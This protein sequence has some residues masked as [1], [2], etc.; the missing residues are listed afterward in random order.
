[1]DLQSGTMDGEEH[2]PQIDIPDHQLLRLIGR[3]SYGQV[4]IARNTIGTYRAV[5]IIRRSSFQHERPFEREIEG[6]RRFEPISRT[7]PG[8]VAI[9]HVGQTPDGDCFYYVM[10]LGDDVQVREKFD[11]DKYEVKTLA[12]AVWDQG[13][14][15]VD[16]CIDIGLSLSD[17]LSYL[18]SNDLIHRDVKPANIIFVSGYPK[19]ADIGLV[20]EASTANTYVGTEGFIPPEGPNSVQGDVYSLGKTLYEISTGQDR[21]QFPSLPAVCLADSSDSNSNFVELVEILNHACDQDTSVRYPTARA[22]HAE[23]TAL[24]NGRSIRRLRLLERRMVF[25][26][27][28][29]RVGVLVLVPLLFLFVLAQ[30]EWQ[31]RIRETSREIGRHEANAVSR[32]VDGDYGT[33]LQH[34]GMALSIAPKDEKSFEHQQ[35]RAASLLGQMPALSYF[36]VTDASVNALRFSRSGESLFAGGDEGF[37]GRFSLVDQSVKRFI[38]HVEDVRS[39][40]YYGEKDL[41]LSAGHDR[42]VRL[43][44]ASTG[45]LLNSYPQ[46]ASLWAVRFSPDGQSFASGGSSKDNIHSLYY[47]SLESTEKPILILPTLDRVWALDFSRDGKTLAVAAGSSLTLLDV[48]TGEVRNTMAHASTI[49]DLSFVDGDKRIATATAGGNYKFWNSK[50]YAGEYESPKQNF[51]IRSIS[52]SPDGRYLVTGGWDYFARVWNQNDGAAIRPVLRHSGRVNAVRFDSLGRRIATGSSDG[53]VRV[54]DLAGQRVPVQYPGYWAANRQGYF[55][56]LED[57]Y[58]RLRK[59]DKEIKL[60]LL[61]N[62]SLLAGK[63]WLPRDRNELVVTTPVSVQSSRIRIV[64]LDAPNTLVSDV[65]ASIG[66]PI[67]MIDVSAIRE[68]VAIAGEKKVAVFSFS[69]NGVPLFEKD[70]ERQIDRVYFSNSGGELFIQ[71]KTAVSICYPHDSSKQATIIRSENEISFSDIDPTDSTLVVCESDGGLDE[72]S[73]FLFDFKKAVEHTSELRHRD[74]VLSADFY[75]NGKSLVTASEDATAIIWDA[76]TGDATGKSFAHNDGIQDV[77][78]TDDGRF[79]FTCSSDKTI[80]LWDSDTALPMMPLVH[81]PSIMGFVTLDKESNQLLCQSRGNPLTYTWDIGRNT[82]PVDHLL[83]YSAVLSG[84]QLDRDQGKALIPAAWEEA[85]IQF[86]SE[87]NV[88]KTQIL[89]WHQWQAFHSLVSKLELPGQYRQSHFDYFDRADKFHY[90]VVRDLTGEENLRYLRYRQAIL[91]WVLDVKTRID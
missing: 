55:T 24:A 88:S 28:I 35:L 26:T 17:A 7:H 60:A 75:L 21:N 19:L 64:S 2:H 57:G 22:M 3:G 52:E 83:R 62:E 46:P 70:M 84:G 79:V 45:E 49:Y 61:N 14:L 33:A 12:N 73:A 11:P 10:E 48:S 90:N 13:R 34:V 71:T 68:C 87:L 15:P 51:A 41:L 59:G 16:R 65:K 78:F 66:E 18:H 36:W 89:R 58:V 4:W 86:P 77:G 76:M 6:I 39:V 8:L 31:R 23:I 30:Q 38:G 74:G 27:R 43:W 80:Q 40:D 91:D 50:T 81:F 42:S 82:F 54:W 72:R 29:A 63:S 32:M 67:R 5:K 56:N 37:V 9:L 20:A 44:K 69:S 53:S 85:K 47:W 25:L 1:M